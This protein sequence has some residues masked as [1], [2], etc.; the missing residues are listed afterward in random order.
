MFVKLKKAGGGVLHMGCTHGVVYYASPLWWQESARDHGDALLSFKYPPTV[1]ISDIAG[2]V[3]RHVNNR[4]QQR[5][6]QP[7]DGRICAQTDANI[8]LAAEGKLTVNLEWMKNFRSN[9]RLAAKPREMDNF[10]CPH[11][12]TSTSDRY[13]LYDRF[14]QKNQKRPEERLR[15]LK[16][17]PDLASLIN[18]AAAEQINR[19]LSSSRYSL[20]QMKDNHFMFSLRLYFHLHNEKLNRSFMKDI[21]K[22]NTSEAIRIGLNGKLLCGRTETHTRKTDQES[23]SPQGPAIGDSSTVD[24]YQFSVSMF[25]INEKNKV[26]S[27]LV[28]TDE[29]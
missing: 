21:E 11:P 28:S 25:P 13:S 17:V 16:L 27:V 20:C 1:Y 4:T 9:P 7:N 29:E 14:H 24:R 22:Q 8:T 12:E 2:R 18:S 3:A 26:T 23:R 10:S 19:E 6:F 15:S 5:F